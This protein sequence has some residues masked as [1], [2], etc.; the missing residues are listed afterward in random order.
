[1]RRHRSALFVIATLTALFAFVGVASAE[2]TYQGKFSGPGNEPGQY[3]EAGRAAVEQATG[4]LFVVDN[5]NGRVQVFKR[6]G[7]GTS[8]SLTSFGSGELSSPWGIAI[9][10]AGGQ[11][12]VYVADAGNERIVKYDSDEAETPSFTLDASFT[13]PAAGS[14]AGEVGSFEAALAIDPSTGDLLVADNANKLIQRF[15]ADGTFVSA[16][17]G[18]AG[19]DS[20]GAFQ[21][22]IDV[23]VN[24]T[25]DVY[26]IDANGP[27]IGT[28]EGTSQAL[29]YSSAGGYEATLMPVGASQRPATVAVHPGDDSVF[30]SGDQDAAWAFSVPSLHRFDTANQPMPTPQLTNAANYTAIAGLT[31]FAGETDRLYVVLN[32]GNQF[33]NPSGEP[34]IH[35]FKQQNPSPPSVT[36]QQA[37]PGKTEAELRAVVDPGNAL[38]SYYFE[39]GATAS[40]GQK[41]HVAKVA[42]EESDIEVELPVRGLS[43]ETEYHFRVV[44]ENSQGTATGPDQTF[45]TLPRGAGDSCGNDDVRQWQ[46]STMLGACRA[47]EMISPPEKN[48]NDIAAHGT[49]V[50]ISADASVA[51]F[52][53]SGA[54]A[55]AAGTGT[56]V[57][58]LARRLGPGEW[59]TEP[60]APPQQPHESVFYG[61]PSYQ[62]FSSDLSQALLISPGNSPLV[63][64]APADSSSI[65]LRG[66]QP[67][68]PSYQLMTPLGVPFPEPKVIEATADLDAV[69]FE[70]AAPLLP[71]AAPGKMNLYLWRNGELTMPSVLPGVGQ[72]APNGSFGSSE[73]SGNTRPTGALSADGSRIVFS[74]PSDESAPLQIYQRE[75]DQIRHISAPQRPISGPD[76]AGT[77]EAVFFGA[78]RDGSRIFF[79][80]E[81]KLTEDSGADSSAR[82]LYM[83]DVATEEL[84]DLTKNGSLPNEYFRGPLGIS[85]DGSYV[86]WIG[87]EPVGAE[88]GDRFPAGPGDSQIWVWHEGSIR[89]VGVSAVPNLNDNR[90]GTGGHSSQATP[91]GRYLIFLSE[92]R[93]AAG[94][95]GGRIAVYL[96][97]YVADDLTCVSCPADGSPQTADAALDTMRPGYASHW[98]QPRWISDDGSKVMF[99]TATPLV[100]GDV[101]GQQDAY[102]YEDGAARLL[103]SGRDDAASYGGTLTASGDDALFLTREGLASKDKDANLDLYDARVGGGAIEAVDGVARCQGDG[104]LDS[105]PPRSA[106]PSPATSKVRNRGEDRRCASLAAK[107][108]Q[109]RRALA[110][111]RKQVA[112]ADGIAAELH[113]KQRKLAAKAKRLSKRANAKCGSGK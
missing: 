104:C 49:R 10:E 99:Q 61:Q 62:W 34:A 94:D 85:E 56:D 36:S 11:T 42:G 53:S 91:D 111:V 5:G 83:Y 97:D 28:Q 79:Y 100:P 109:A 55:G 18:S 3:E 68:A 70:S 87:S 51:D 20:P 78:S 95:N 38:L 72:T 9:A 89:L 113:A 93:L 64:G 73:K 45:V 71:D 108:R 24:S 8:E 77:Q 82:D 81:E 41:T 37:F 65:Y 19:D 23:A 50:K 107:A 32:R 31:V 27:D 96:Y 48:G 14:G 29:R 4:N 44:I 21:G 105:L 60:I 63:P 33:G 101:N 112:K 90:G 57:E 92:K 102:L 7:T 12:S 15:E 30:V 80:S 98:Q 43:P 74:T 75:G 88:D 22:P 84:T 59:L 16:F 2:F 26:V 47:W 1:M 69:L 46:G 17:D 86:S 67:G 110:R 39:W 76:P 58:Y 35:V 6:S 25:G 13:S 103:S 52:S 40:Y 106:A 54:F 66:N